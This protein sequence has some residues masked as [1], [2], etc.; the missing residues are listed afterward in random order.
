[1]VTMERW[2]QE[3]RKP[4]EIFLSNNAAVNFERAAEA[5]A[6]EVYL[7]SNFMV[8]MPEFAA[9]A[10]KTPGSL[11]VQQYRPNAPRVLLLLL[12]T[13]SVYLSWLATS[14]PCGSQ[15]RLVQRSTLQRSWP[16]SQERPMLCNAGS[17]VP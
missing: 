11:A 1:M 2:L 9:S 12:L 14:N 15:G 3:H 4:V 10:L 7:G 5:L 13:L 8:D 6:T 16:R 17:R